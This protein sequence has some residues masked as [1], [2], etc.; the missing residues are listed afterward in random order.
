MNDGLLNSGISK[1]S[2]GI[3]SDFTSGKK[4]CVMRKKIDVDLQKDST[5]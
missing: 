2:S 1:K 4:F 3:N 5:G